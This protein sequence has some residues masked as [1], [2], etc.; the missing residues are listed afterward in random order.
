MIRAMYGRINECKFT[1]YTM[2][3]IDPSI[4]SLLCGW[5]TVLPSLSSVHQ[6]A[7]HLELTRMHHLV[8]TP[9]LKQGTAGAE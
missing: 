6:A 8:D 1:H 4:C 2:H 3:T 9:G 5:Y 7:A